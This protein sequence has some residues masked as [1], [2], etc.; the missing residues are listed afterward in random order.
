MLIALFAPLIAISAGVSIY[1]RQK[2]DEAA[3]A[4]CKPI[5]TILIITLTV[6]LNLERD[7]YYGWVVIAG[8]VLSLI[9]D[10]LLLKEKLFVHG[11]LAFLLAHIV[12]IYAFSSLHGFQS[13][14][15]VLS[16]LLVVGGGYF[17]FL[18][19]HLKS[20][21]I[22]VA[23]YFLAI[24]M[25]DWQA[26]GL[27]ISGNETIYYSL[28]LSSVMFSFSDAVIAYNKF[29]KE[30]KAAEFLILSTYWAAIFIIGVSVAF[31]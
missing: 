12:F 14:F 7:L 25:M 5:T 6:L 3:Y 26:L 15:I 22:P 30:F 4:V 1:F 10:V 23:L 8:L 28:G 17:V 29:V 16:I 24:I 20:F 21:A 18:L 19:P 31:V 9:G 13:N 2:N 11:L 27:S